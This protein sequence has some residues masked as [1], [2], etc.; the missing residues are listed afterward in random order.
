LF[1]LLAVVFFLLAAA[2]SLY[3]GGGRDEVLSHADQLIENKQY[4]DAIQVLTDYTKTNPEK[5]KDSQKRLQQIVQLRERYNTIADELLDVLV[6]DPENN[7]KILELTQALNAIEPPTTPLAGKFLNQIRDLAVFN[8]NRN[9]LERIL[10]EGRSRLEQG[11]YTGAMEA[12]AAGLDIYQSEFFASGYGEDAE[13]DAR[14]GLENISRDISDFYALF[15]PFNQAAGAVENTNR[16]LGLDVLRED[17]D[18]LTGRMEELMA[19]RNNFYQVGASFNSRQEILQR[20]NAAMGDRSFLSFA[21]RLIHGPAGQTEGMLGVLDRYWEQRIASAESAV[22]GLRDSFYNEAYSAALNR[23]YA[24]AIPLLE[25]TEGYISISRDFLNR[26][27]AYEEDNN[28][29][30]QVIFE[31]RVLQNKTDEYLNYQA[32]GRSIAVLKEAEALGVRETAL[33]EG[34]FPALGSWQEGQLEG[35]AAIAMEEEIRAS[36][37]V[38]KDEL[39]LLKARLDGETVLIRN[40]QGAYE[41][42]GAGAGNALSFMDNAHTLIGALESLVTE[43]ISNSAVR[44][45]TI[46]NGDFEKIVIERE[47]EFEEADS[48]MQGI[49]QTT[50]GGGEYTARYPSEGLIILTRLGQSLAVNLTAGRGLLSRYGDESPDMLNSV[51]IQPLYSSA[52]S[53]VNRLGSLQSRVGPLAAAARTQVSQAE[54]FRLEGDRLVQEART[55][56]GR[57]NLDLARERLDRA[58]ERYQ[59][60]LAIQESA[61]IRSIWDTQLVALGDEIKARQNEIVVRDVR[62]LLTNVRTTYY[63]GNFEQAEGLLIR[64][65]NLWRTTNSTENPEVRYWINLVRGAQS[66]QAGKTIPV[67][68]PL[69]AEMSQLL[70]EAKRNYDEGTRMINS[71]RRQVGLSSF[72]EARQK[73]QEIRLMFPMNQEARLLELRM[74]QVTDPPAFAAAFD[75]RLNEA[76]AGTRPPTRSAES[77]ATLQELAIINPLYPGMAGIIRQAEIDIGIRPPDPDPRAVAQSRE[78]TLSARSI[79]DAYNTVQYAIAQT[80]L[81]QAILLNPNNNEAIILKDV[82]QTRMTGTGV[83]VLDSVSQDL[84]N[85]A[86]QQ[87]Q[88]GNNL[89]AY[90]IV[91]Q[92]LQNPKIRNATII[93]DLQRRIESVL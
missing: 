55:A 4:D 2:A 6:N 15:S 76:R 64:A 79:I 5:F 69:Y 1:R 32:M 13:A 37:S 46:A 91:Q 40:Y 90:A 70:S 72:A 67:T 84:Y 17:Y 7:E 36:Y 30:V 49:T 29:P 86:V 16:E 35:A 3:A 25:T 56:L 68:A 59:S 31:E 62:A 48:L 34:G 38:L 23:E 89:N 19:I 41:D 74:E 42:S 50:E 78:L 58:L 83:F 12:Y 45:Y 66:L 65:Q 21:S 80:Q 82:V 20:D 47:G 71:G 28:P 63:N 85:Q 57:D 81:D 10:V 9:R 61:S 88:L 14:E 24:G 87:L 27:L 73:T 43:Q 60:S 8:Q 54:A 26:R 33:S 11:D 51:E 22:S 18:N 92:L 77:F 39:T 93:Q 75:Q 52:Q 44:R 53:L